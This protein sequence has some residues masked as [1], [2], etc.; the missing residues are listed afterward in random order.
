M[1]KND[2]SHVLLDDRAVLATLAR[3]EADDVIIPGGSITD[4][5]DIA[6]TDD[7][8]GTSTACDALSNLGTARQYGW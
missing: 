6:V 8:K 4:I 3:Q 7:G 5:T 1:T 2:E